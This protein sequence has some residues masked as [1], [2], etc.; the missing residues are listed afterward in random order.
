[1]TVIRNLPLM[2][3][4][5]MGALGLAA[6]SC[7]REKE[8][9]YPAP[10]PVLIEAP[11]YAS[12]ATNEQPDNPLTKE[13]VVLGRALF[14]ETALSSDGKVACSSC[15]D[16]K[17]GFSDPRRFSIGVDGKVGRRNSMAL[18][19]LRF[20]Q[21]FFWDG[22]SPTLEDQ[23]TRPIQDPL[24]MGMTPLKVEEAVSKI[25]KYKP[26]FGKA[27]G[28]EEITFT[29]ATKA[30]AQYVR[31][32][33]SFNSKY[34]QYLLG[35]YTPKAEELEGMRLFFTHPT[36]PSSSGPGVRG[37]N[38]GDCHFAPLLDGR[39]I[40]FEG[41]KNNGTS[42]YPGDDIGLMEVTHDT[43]DF[44]K[45]KIP[46][47][48]NIALTAPYMHDGRFETL[49]EVI[50]HYNNPE[51]AYHPHIDNL[52]KLGTNERFGSSLDLREEEKQQL[53]AFL[54]MLTDTTLASK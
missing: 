34:D 44:G 19:N 27:F 21:H 45:F 30:I 2:S 26:M 48:R 22:R 31:T 39:Q 46:S 6:A 24:E 14:F 3:F 15:H 35:Q 13:G 18:A 40:G 8:F 5:I 29:K 25:D 50:N 42:S 4:L 51:L 43:A 20:E 36:P 41:F 49:E 52:I 53:L 16:P 28:S 12:S 9:S 47:L 32:L 1:M 10:T 7:K 33:T 37:A 17:H 54:H 11:A 38:C 23:A